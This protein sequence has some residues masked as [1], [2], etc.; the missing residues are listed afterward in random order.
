MPLKDPTFTIGI[1]EEYLL[2]EQASRDLVREMP[3]ALFED[4][5]R[6][7]RGH[8]AR[9]YLKSQIEVETEIHKTPAEAGAQ[10]SQARRT[11]AQLAAQH[12]LAPIAP[13]THPFARSRYLNGAL[14]YGE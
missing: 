11:V 3:Q 5:E 8:V 10:L 6:A 2:V 13:S 12:G 4:C 1:E 9:E 7:L 14:L